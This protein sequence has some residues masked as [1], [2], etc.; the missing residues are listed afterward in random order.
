MAGGEETGKWSRSK[1]RPAKR[2]WV[3]GEEVSQGRQ[4]GDWY[5]EK[6]KVEAGREETSMWRRGKS[7]QAERRQVCGE[8]VSR[9]SHRGDR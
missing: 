5:V 2:R 7:R 4:R 9:G 6:R 3:C 1:L 8:E